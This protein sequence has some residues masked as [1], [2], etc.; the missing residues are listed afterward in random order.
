MGI[1]EESLNVG[2]DMVTE[3]C[4]ENRSE[5]RNP[6]NKLRFTKFINDDLIL[7]AS[8]WFDAAISFKSAHPSPPTVIE[9][10]PPVVTIEWKLITGFIAM[11]GV[12][13]A[14]FYQPQIRAGE[15]LLSPS[16]R[17]RGGLFRTIARLLL[18]LQLFVRLP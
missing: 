15:Q 7:F 10:F 17:A 11:G 14:A 4:R 12:S 18:R 2:L 13:A 1:L 16:K 9:D 5:M 6:A 8:R 3:H